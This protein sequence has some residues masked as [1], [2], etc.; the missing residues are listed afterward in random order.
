M[1]RVFYLLI[2]STIIL[3]SCAKET[4]FINADGTT[5]KTGPTT[6]VFSIAG[7][8]WRMT[9]SSSVIEANGTTNTR[10]EFATMDPCE[11]DDILIYRANGVYALDNGANKCFDSDPQIDEQG[12]WTLSADNK[13]LTITSTIPGPFGPIAVSVEILQLDNTTLKTSYYYVINNIKTT[14]TDTFVKVI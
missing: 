10:N 7:T 5:S 3:S 9:A 4:E 2:A 12:R 13:T 1:K 11:I 14:T 8:S 6:P